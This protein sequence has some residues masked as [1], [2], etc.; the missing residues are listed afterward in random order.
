LDS[1][2]FLRDEVFD[3]ECLI[4]DRLVTRRFN[5]WPESAVDQVRALDAHHGDRDERA[6][7]GF[8][9]GDVALVVSIGAV[10]CCDDHA[11]VNDVHDQ[12]RPNPSASSSSIWRVIPA[13]DTRIAPTRV[14]SVS[15]ERRNLRCRCAAVVV[16]ALI[17]PVGGGG[18][19][20]WFGS[21]G[22]GSEPFGEPVDVE[23]C[24]GNGG[25][26]VHGVVM[27]GRG[28][29]AAVEL[30]EHDHRHERG[31]FVPVW[32]QMVVRQ[33]PAQHG[34]LSTTSG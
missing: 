6:G 16:T 21:G 2:P 33:V 3:P 15:S 32:E 8:Q 25:H 17:L 24:A 1:G 27:V 7:F 9:H 12:S 20:D 4:E 31:A 18:G 23:V 19:G 34:G 28:P 13:G 5:R 26:G 14:S 11:G 22:V 30:E 10:G 29:G